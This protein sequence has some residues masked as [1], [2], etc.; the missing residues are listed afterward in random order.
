MQNLRVKNLYAAFA[1]KNNSYILKGILIGALIGFVVGVFR[2]IIDNTLKGLFWVYPYLVKHPLM[3]IV[4][5]I[6]TVIVWLALT[7]VVKPFAKKDEMSWWSG[8]WRTF[9]G[10]LLAIC[11]GLFAGREG[12]CI[13][14]GSY[15]AR[16]CSVNLFHDNEQD[17]KVLVHS[18]MSAGL[19]AAFSAPIAGTLFILE[20]I[21]FEFTPVILITSMTT[22]ISSVVVTYFFFGI[23]PCLYLAYSGSLPLESYWLLLILGILMGFL[24]WV[25]QIT[26]TQ[27]K[28]LY[29]LLPIPKRFNTILPLLFVIPIGLIYPKILGGSHDFISVLTS[30]Q[31][32]HSVLNDPKYTMIGVIIVFALVRFVFTMISCNATAPTGIFM[33]ILV[34]GAVTGALYAALVIRF[35]LISDI[36]YLNIIICAMAAYFGAALKTPFTA[37]VL[38]VETVGSVKYVMPILIVTWIAYIVNSWL[39]GKS[40]FND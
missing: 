35:G 17:L 21:S 23:K 19:A 40:V 36:Y 16:G 4:Y 22:S 27:T 15:I 9:V 18:G 30:D 37:V 38:L 3:I 25:F 39:K 32:M 20:A 34:M 5:V 7:R 24:A 33:P 26:N 29:E 12:P 31:F 6:G 28:K 11:P 10:A 2:L 14:M 8:L 1:S 13:Q